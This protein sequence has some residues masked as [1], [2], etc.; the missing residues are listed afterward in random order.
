MSSVA[1]HLDSH[2][3]ELDSLPDVLFDQLEIDPQ[4]LNGVRQ[5]IY[6][7]Y[8]ILYGRHTRKCTC[9]GQVN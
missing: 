6:L 9:M 8:E 1:S 4:I 2:Q 5:K 7:C 3:M